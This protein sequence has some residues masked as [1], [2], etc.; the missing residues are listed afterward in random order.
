MRLENGGGGNKWFGCQESGGFPNPTDTH[1]H[2]HARKHARTRSHLFLILSIFLQ[3]HLRGADTGPSRALAQGLKR[4]TTVV[5]Q[6]AG[7]R[8]RSGTLQAGLWG[9]SLSATAQRPAVL[10]PPGRV[11]SRSWRCLGDPCVLAHGPSAGALRAGKPDL[12]LP[13]PKE[14]FSTGWGSKEAR[15]VPPT[16]KACSGLY[17]SNSRLPNRPSPR[18]C[19]P[20]CLPGCRRTLRSLSTPGK[21]Q[22]CSP[23]HHHTK[24]WLLPKARGFLPWM[25][26]QARA[27]LAGGQGRERA[28]AVAMALAPR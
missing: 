24:L 18:V 22:R 3:M 6:T 26:T 23:E 8:T 20:K 19:T 15:K 13:A 2:T 12:L 16:P 17:Y 5:V 7:A 1:K 25:E 14:R 21:P 27:V 4:E 9:A 11:W 28:A 10:L